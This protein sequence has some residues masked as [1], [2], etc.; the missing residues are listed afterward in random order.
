MLWLATGSGAALLLWVLLARSITIYR[1]VATDANGRNTEQGSFGSKASAKTL[2]AKIEKAGGKNISVVSMRRGDSIQHRFRDGLTIFGVAIT[3][4]LFWQAQQLLGRG[5]DLRVLE[6]TV[7]ENLPAICISFL[8]AWRVTPSISRNKGVVPIAWTACCVLA[9]LAALVALRI[10]L[11]LSFNFSFSDTES[12]TVGVLLVLIIPF[13]LSFTFCA[14]LSKAFARTNLQVAD[15][16]KK[17]GTPDY[18]VFCLSTV[19]LVSVFFAMDEFHPTT[20]KKIAAGI[21]PI[22][23]SGSRTFVS[24]S[25]Q[26]NKTAITRSNTLSTEKVKTAEEQ[27]QACRT[28]ADLLA[29]PSFST[30]FYSRP[31]LYGFAGK[32]YIFLS[33]YTE[34]VR[35]DY[36]YLVMTPCMTR[37]GWAGTKQQTSIEN[38]L[39][40]FDASKIKEFAQLMARLN[41]NDSGRFEAST[42]TNSTKSQPVPSET[43]Y[44]PFASGYDPFPLS[45]GRQLVKR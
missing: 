8:I 30:Y 27:A 43:N 14:V 35:D 38:F 36:I 18:V 15:I 7:F 28:E 25:V 16:G 42:L 34:S 26:Q 6:G 31:R 37:V 32:D 17:S 21:A 10:Q 4:L 5:I 33:P 9:A 41:Q 2:C 22:P 39:A 29:L 13:F 19:I 3:A 1:V 45:D 20:K 40:K 23:E 12:D 24:R 44:D 11:Y